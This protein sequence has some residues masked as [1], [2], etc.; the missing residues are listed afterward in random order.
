[1]EKRERKV[2]GNCRKNRQLP[3]YTMT[4]LFAFILLLTNGYAF[5]KLPREDNDALL[6]ALNP[7]IKIIRRNPANFIPDDDMEIS[8]FENVLWIDRAMVEDDG[9]I[10]RAM[11]ND[12]VEW[13]EKEEYARNWNL[14]ST[15]VYFAP[16][17]EHKKRYVEKNILK[18]VDKRLAGEVKKSEE[19]SA[20]HTVGKMQRAL[21]PTGTVGIGRKI[22][23]KFRAR[24]V[25]GE[26]RIIVIN[27]WVD[28]H[29]YANYRGD[30]N[31]NLSK[32]FKK[33][34]I[35]TNMVYDISGHSWEAS[36]SKK[37]TRRVVGKLSSIQSEKQ[38]MFASESNKIIQFSYSLPF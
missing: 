10:L 4:V 27:P 37:I 33:T 38:M 26:G 20:L 12:V 7:N 19:G 11:K 30:V 9:G 13:Q 3:F 35:S 21:K 15:G 29:T 22:K 23:F 8:P 28:Y 24:V 14:Q 2:H 18:Y 36:V 5:D 17:R 32:N 31:M 16:D 25:Q 34:G 6:M 1:M